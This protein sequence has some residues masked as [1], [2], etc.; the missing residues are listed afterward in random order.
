MAL[1]STS[2]DV[3][4]SFALDA[5]ALGAL[6]EQAKSDPRA[7]LKAAAGQFEA[8]FM[9]MLLKSMRDALPQDGAF[10]S[11]TTKPLWGLFNKQLAQQLSKKGLGISDILVKH[12]SGVVG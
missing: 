7:A 3:S 9:Q 1:A 8:L 11:D 10:A 5:N 4:G 12:L 2:T 6:K